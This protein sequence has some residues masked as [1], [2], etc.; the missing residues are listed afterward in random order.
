M[1]L[2]KL[3]KTGLFLYI[4]VL[5]TNAMRNIAQFEYVTINDKSVDGVHMEIEPGMAGWKAQTNLLSYGNTPNN[6]CL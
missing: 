5:F 3:A 4:F 2:K 1:L 6:Y